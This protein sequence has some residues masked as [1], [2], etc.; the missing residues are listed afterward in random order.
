MLINETLARRERGKVVVACSRR[1]ISAPQV[2]MQFR[3]PEAF[4]ERNSHAVAP[5][6]VGG[7]LYDRVDSVP[8]HEALV[9]IGGRRRDNPNAI[10]FEIDAGVGQH[11]AQ[12]HFR[13]GRG[14]GNPKPLESLE[15][16]AFD[17]ERRAYRQEPVRILRQRAQQLY[18]LPTGKR[19]GGHES[20]PADKVQFPVAHELGAFQR[21]VDKR[22]IDAL[23]LEQAELDGR[24]SNEIRRRIQIGDP[25]SNH[26]TTS[27]PPAS[28]MTLR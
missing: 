22:N 2:E 8:R 19:P 7:V 16:S 15:I 14:G 10:S 18:P 4:A 13:P 23:L 17:I 26:A 1:T 21:I 3:N 11:V 6:G 20:G 9:P 5:I 25:Y 12:R 27:L 24:Y 28:R